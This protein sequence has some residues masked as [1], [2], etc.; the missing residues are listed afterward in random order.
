MIHF[1]RTSLLMSYFLLVLSY[2]TFTTAVCHNTFL[3]GPTICKSTPTQ[4]LEHPQGR[5]CVYLQC[6]EWY[7]VSN[8]RLGELVKWGK[9]YNPECSALHSYYYCRYENS[10]GYILMKLPK[11]KWL[12]EQHFKS[13]RN[14]KY[15]CEKLLGVESS[16]HIF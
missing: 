9:L 2:L 16:F 14:V 12:I 4:N 5:S 10:G 13:P 6:S 8:C 7:Q 11:S 15:H 3:N 1:N